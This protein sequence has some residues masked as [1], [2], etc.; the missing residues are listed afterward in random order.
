MSD[1]CIGFRV[2]IVSYELVVVVVVVV[3]VN[4]RLK[5]WLKC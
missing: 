4:M 5:L 1:F 2:L 3:C